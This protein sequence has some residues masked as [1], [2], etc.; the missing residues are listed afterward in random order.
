MKLL[1]CAK[2][3]VG[4]PP[5]G[6]IDTMDPKPPPPPKVTE[7][8]IV[9]IPLLPPLPPEDVWWGDGVKPGDA[10]ITVPVPLAPQ[11]AGLTKVDAL[12]PTPEAGV[13]LSNAALE[14]GAAEFIIPEVASNTV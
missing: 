8:W 12:K 9:E 1:W 6:G 10:D 4:P 3:F 11:D 14:A 5:P 7:L 2:E 13:N